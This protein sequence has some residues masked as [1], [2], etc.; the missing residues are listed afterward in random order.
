MTCCLQPGG[1]GKQVD[2]ARFDPWVRKIPR[3]R[4]WQPTAVSVPGEFPGQEP[5]RLQS[6]GVTESD[7]TE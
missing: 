3:R 4:K 6:L 5:G 7:T 2:S 1:S